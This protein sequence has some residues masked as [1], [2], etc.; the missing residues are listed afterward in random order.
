[1]FLLGF[2]ILDIGTK[3]L[4]DQFFDYRLSAVTSAL[5]TEVPTGNT[6][7]GR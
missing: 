2:S 7:V 3:V 4:W 6:S 5:A 1:V